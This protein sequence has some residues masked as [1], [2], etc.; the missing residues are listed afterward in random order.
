[1]VPIVQ[2]QSS[3]NG[4]L[5]QKE[6][7]ETKLAIVAGLAFTTTLLEVDR[8]PAKRL[9][10]SRSQGLFAGVA[11]EGATLGEDLDAN[12]TLYGSKLD[13]RD[14]GDRRQGCP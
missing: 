6:E 5:R 2:W 7:E 1:M 8:E 13:N 10:W 9:A 11:L 12:A 14:I 4:H 3:G